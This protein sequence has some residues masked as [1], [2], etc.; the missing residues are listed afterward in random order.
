MEATLHDIVNALM[1]ART[2]AESMADHYS[3]Y[4]GAL[5][6]FTQEVGRVQRD[7]IMKVRSE[8]LEEK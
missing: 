4:R 2:H 6:R 3:E 7:L 8:L 5:L 1:V